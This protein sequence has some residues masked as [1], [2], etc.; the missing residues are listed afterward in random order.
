M[1]RRTGST[2]TGWCSKRGPAIH[3]SSTALSGGADDLAGS[4][5][6]TSYYTGAAVQSIVGGA[7]LTADFDDAQV[8]GSGGCNRFNGSVD[9]SRDRI[10]I[11]P[12]A[13]TMALC[14]DPQLQ[15]QE[16][17]YF[18]ALELATTYLVTGD[19]LDLFRADGGFAATFDRR[20][21]R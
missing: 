9:V 16:D 11:G 10:T 5:I 3:C 2:E 8:S 19:R 17:H 1:H 14:T 7:E 21:P 13:S 20:V 6:V 15:T 4:W 18:A 12:L